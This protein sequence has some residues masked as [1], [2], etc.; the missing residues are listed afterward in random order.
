MISVTPSGQRCSATV[1]GVDLASKLDPSTVGATHNAWLTHH[2]LV[3]QNQDLDDT[4]F[5]TFAESICPIGADP[6]FAPTD[7][8][9]RIAAISR[10]ADEAGPLF[11]EV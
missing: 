6:F 2:V 9:K 8:K 10:R 11:A 3:F 4:A 1:L 5:E 7:G